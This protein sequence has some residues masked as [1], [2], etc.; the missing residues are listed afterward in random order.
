MTIG[1]TD[2]SKFDDYRRWITAENGVDVIRLSYKERN[3]HLVDKCDGVLLSGGDE[4][5]HPRFYNKIEYLEFCQGTDEHRDEF[6]WKILQH[7]ETS[8]KPV[9]GICKGLQIANVFFGG[10]LI[11]DIP[12][13]GKFNHSKFPAVDR[14]HAIH[15]DKNS[16][17]H[18]ISGK[19]TGEINSAH[20]QSADRIGTGLIA[21]AISP[22][23]IVEGLERK[24]SDGKSFLLLVQWHP[25]RMVNQESIFSKNIRHIFLRRV[26]EQHP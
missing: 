5:V 1:I 14:H 25:E 7:T 19:E 4:D 6:E 24:H 13:F 9:L 26:S 23:G 22:D 8:N 2:C 16:E 20:H 12:A 18:K 15:V 21:N 17:L 10:S 3:F 11:P